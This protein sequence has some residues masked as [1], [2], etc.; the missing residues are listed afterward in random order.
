MAKFT[1]TFEDTKNGGMKSSI[2]LIGFKD[3][4]GQSLNQNTCVQNLYF[5]LNNFMV[6]ELGLKIPPIQVKDAH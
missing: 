4:P 2:D 3:V 1:I 6:A 5:A